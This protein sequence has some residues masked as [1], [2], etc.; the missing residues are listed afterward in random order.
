MGMVNNL[1]VNIPLT[2]FDFFG[3]AGG[4]W[5]LAHIINGLLLL[6]FAVTIIW[7][8]YKEKNFLILKLSVL[9]VVL[10]ITAI[11]CG[12]LFLVIYSFPS[13]YFSENYFSLAMALSFLCVFTVFF[14]D[15]Y[16][17]KKAQKSQVE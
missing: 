1:F 6:S 2:P 8:S 13:L 14:S 9:S 5:I 10:T 17:S 16:A 4:L 7:F 15:L 3:Y 11:A 12:I